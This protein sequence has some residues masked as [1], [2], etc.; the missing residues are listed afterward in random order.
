MFVEILQLAKLLKKFLFRQ[1]VG[2]YKEQC[3]KNLPDENFF[4]QG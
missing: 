3:N 4:E 1:N 2:V